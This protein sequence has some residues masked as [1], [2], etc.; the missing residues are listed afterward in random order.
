MPIYSNNRTGSMAL[1]QVAAN[2]SYTSEDFGRILYE[3]QLNDM[4]FFEAVLACD[5][6]EI[7]GLRE[8]TI[9]ESEVKALNEASFKEM[10][11]KVVVGLK[12]FWAKLKGAF[13]DAI[14]KLGAWVGNNGK[15]LAKQVSDAKMDSKWDGSIENVV[16][17]DYS[18]EKLATLKGDMYN[19][20]FRAIGVKDI[21]VASITGEY[22]GRMVGAGHAVNAAEY[23]KMCFDK[24]RRTETLNK[25]NINAFVKDI[26]SA[27]FHIAFMKKYQK[28]VEKSINDWI[29]DLRSAAKEEQNASKL[30][31]IVRA[32]ETIVAT[33]CKTNIA[34]T[35]ADL[36]SRAAAITR[37]LSDARKSV[38]E[39]AEVEV[40]CVIESFDEAMTNTL[41]MDAETKAAVAELVAAC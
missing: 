25:S 14:N 28:A 17:F 36:K 21:N 33:M 8:G 18:N 7:K 11:D 40:R 20:L 6:N 23:S 30:N 4:A 34:I 2:E 38:Q 41:N 26:D 27:S 24:A 1:A 12:K 13:Q 9:L 16:T 10:I 15:A 19:E 5:F 37:A 22:L 32:Y 35:R 31:G 29:D 39:A 3:S